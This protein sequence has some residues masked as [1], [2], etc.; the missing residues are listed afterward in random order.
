MRHVALIQA[1]YLILLNLLQLNAALHGKLLH[2]CA[3]SRDLIESIPSELQPNQPCKG[4]CK[5][6]HPISEDLNSSH[7]VLTND[8]LVAELDAQAST[9][10]DADGH[11]GTCNPFTCVKCHSPS[12]F[13]HFYSIQ[14]NRDILKEKVSTF[15]LSLSTLRL[16]NIWHP[17]I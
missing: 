6:D 3:S 1:I 13:F 2:C 15:V 17:P 5:H 12:F 10:G 4:T 14:F 9:C 16:F 8:S 7:I 11:C